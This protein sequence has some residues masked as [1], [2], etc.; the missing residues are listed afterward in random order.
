[1]D[2]TSKRRRRRRKEGKTNS[3]KKLSIGSFRKFCAITPKV[4]TVCGFNARLLEGD[5]VLIYWISSQVAVHNATA[6]LDRR[7]E[8]WTGR[9]EVVAVVLIPPAVV[10]QLTSSPHEEEQIFNQRL[11]R[12]ALKPTRALMVNIRR[13]QRRTRPIRKRE[14]K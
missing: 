13:A 8:E 11:A 1:M 10:I 6:T 5:I 14:I 7:R 2:A 3:A 12:G 4:F 9:E